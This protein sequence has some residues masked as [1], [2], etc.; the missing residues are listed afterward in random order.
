MAN[1]NNFSLSLIMVMSVD[2]KTTKWFDPSIYNWTSQEDKDHFFAHI[3]KSNAII[4]GRKTYDAAKSV[5]HLSPDTLRIVITR[6]PEHYTHATVEHQLEFWNTTPDQTRTQLI[7]RG[8]SQAL[9]VGGE[10]LNAVF[11]KEHLVDEL[12][13]TIEPR[14]FGEGNNLVAQSKLDHSL[15]LENITSLNDQG[16]ILLKYKVLHP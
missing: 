2:G 1:K 8:Y 6:N 3:K 4:M 9:L 7:K 11:F 12:Y 14:I 16:T 5:M 15:R 10:S 13:L